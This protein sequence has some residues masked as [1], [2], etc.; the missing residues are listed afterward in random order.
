MGA[1]SG[2]MRAKSIVAVA[3]ALIG[4]LA[5]GVSSGQEPGNRLEAAAKEFAKRQIENSFRS[6]NRPFEPFRMIG[7]IYYV[8]ASDVASYLIAT[9]E[10]HILINSGFEDTVPLIRDGVR[11]LGFRFEDIKVLLNSHAHIDHAGGHA[12]LKK[13]TG[14]RI[15][16]SEADA[17][18]L[19]NGGKG[20]F[21]PVSEEVVDY[22]PARADRIIGDGEHVTLGG[23]DAH[24]SPDARSHQG[25][26]HLDDGCRRGGE[27][28]QRGHLWEHDDPSRS[29]AGR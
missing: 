18:L 24:R 7:N 20:D 8:G 26:H 16:M 13:L 29:A 4:G 10:G 11:K 17:E 19:A 15:V 1:E 6:M 5:V 3:V 23:V 22:Q 25:L 9:P 28:L 27:D 12:L 2:T 14:A 21:L